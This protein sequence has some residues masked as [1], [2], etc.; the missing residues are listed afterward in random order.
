MVRPKNEWPPLKKMDRINVIL[1]RM[2]FNYILNGEKKERV[3]PNWLLEPDIY[4]SKYVVDFTYNIYLQHI[5]FL[6]YICALIE[7]KN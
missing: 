7:A 3:R 6:Q 4:L 2:A 1:Q 5:K